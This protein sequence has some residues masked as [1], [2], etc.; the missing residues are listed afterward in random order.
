M[1]LLGYWGKIAQAGLL[2]LIV[3][4]VRKELRHVLLFFVEKGNWDDPIQLAMIFGEG[5]EF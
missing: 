2:F 4:L 1:L 3:L 5:K